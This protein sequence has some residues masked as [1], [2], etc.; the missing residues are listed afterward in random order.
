MLAACHRE[1]SD[2]PRETRIAVDS[3]ELL[4]AVKL[5]PRFDGS[6]ASTLFVRGVAEGGSLVASDM[7]TGRKKLKVGRIIVQ[8]V[9][10]D[11]VNVL[12]AFKETADNSF[13]HLAMFI[14]TILVTAERTITVTRDMSSAPVRFL[15]RAV[16]NPSGIVFLANAAGK[17]STSAAFH[18]ALLEL[19]S[20]AHT[21]HNITKRATLE[22]GCQP[23]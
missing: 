14:L 5:S 22:R 17:D 6:A 18:T 11:M 23:A 4:C 3:G 8:F 7:F 1:A 16:A 15:R 13:H 2:A 21:T 19:F 12:R 20:V 9:A 10:V